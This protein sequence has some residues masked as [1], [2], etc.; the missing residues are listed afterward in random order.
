[1]QSVLILSDPSN[2]HLNKLRGCPDFPGGLSAQVLLALYLTRL[3]PFWR[4]EPDSW[5]AGEEDAE[6][7]SAVLF[8]NGCFLSRTLGN[9]FLLISFQISSVQMKGDLWVWTAGLIACPGM[10]MSNI[11]STLE[12]LKG[13]RCSKGPESS[14][15]TSQHEWGTVSR[16]QWHCPRNGLNVKPHPAKLQGFE[17]LVSS[18]WYCSAGFWEK[19]VFFQG[20]L[21]GL[22]AG[23]TFCPFSPFYLFFPF[24]SDMSKLSLPCH[25]LLNSEPQD[26]LL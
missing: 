23:P 2:I 1:M 4:E 24:R 5:K 26:F 9:F 12:G 11:S 13:Q 7:A 18:W 20:G 3:C 16:P 21:W 6:E 15:C 8:F 17:H 14:T 10:L 22:Q 25:V 19:T